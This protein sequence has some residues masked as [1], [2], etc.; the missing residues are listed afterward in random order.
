MFLPEVGVVEVGGAGAQ[1]GSSLILYS[2]SLPCTMSG[3]MVPFAF[4]GCSVSG[5]GQPWGFVQIPRGRSIQQESQQI[6]VMDLFLHCDLK[7]LKPHKTFLCLLSLF[8][9]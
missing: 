2:P 5:R 9:Y 8:P 1:E 6:Y 3:I 7:F 4:M